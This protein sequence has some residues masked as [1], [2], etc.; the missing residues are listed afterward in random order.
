VFLRISE[1]VVT[2]GLGIINRFVF[3]TETECVYC[4][5]RAESLY[6]IGHVSSLK[7]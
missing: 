1:Q 6:K 2:F 7:G 5:V 3:L 4:A